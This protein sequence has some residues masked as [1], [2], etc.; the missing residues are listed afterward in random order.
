MKR[1][2]KDEQHELYKQII[3]MAEKSDITTADVCRKLHLDIHKA[4]H[5]LTR[6]VD[7]QALVKNDSKGRKHRTWSIGWNKDLCL[8]NRAQVMVQIKPDIAALWLLPKSKHHW[9]V[10]FIPIVR[11][12][13][14]G[15]RRDT[16]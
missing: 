12:G 10:K 4:H 15:A 13:E 3:A 6:L 9:E 14:H 5:C 2:S 16:L 11:S 8:P 7:M 1:T